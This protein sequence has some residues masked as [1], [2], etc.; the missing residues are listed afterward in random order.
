MTTRM[1]KLCSLGLLSACLFAGPASAQ[2]LPPL[3]VCNTDS[4][5]EQIQRAF[6][7][8]KVVKTLNTMTAL[9][10]IDPASVAAGDHDIFVSGND[11]DAKAR[12]SALL[13]EWFGWKSVIDLGDITTARG[14]EMVLPLWLR[15]MGALNTPM[16]NLK[17]VR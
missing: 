11:A 6:P 7:T 2:P 4:L 10:M 14:T 8:A 5:G 16:F 3:S 17:V 13:K 9:V 1:L 15:L 12:V